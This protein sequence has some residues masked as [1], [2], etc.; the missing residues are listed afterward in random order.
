MY[1]YP[2]QHKGTKHD[3]MV[4][5]TIC[6][7]VDDILARGSR[8]AT[9][10]FWDRGAARFPVK[11]WEVVEYDNPVT[12]CAKRISKIKRNGKI[13]YTIDQTRDIEVF[14]ADAGMSAVRATSAPMPYKQD[15]MSDTTLLSEQEHKQYR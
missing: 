1:H 7:H 11:H 5:M 6:T 14:L 8:L 12:Y 13:W 15:I 9:Q 3:T 10:Y 2:R 4:G